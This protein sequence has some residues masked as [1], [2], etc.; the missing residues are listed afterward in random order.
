L[1]LLSLPLPASGP[2]IRIE[3]PNGGEV[4][5][6]GTQVAVRWRTQGIE[7][8]LA[9]LLFKNGEQQAILANGIPDNGLFQ[10]HVATGLAESTG[11]RLRLC[12]LSDLRLNDFSDRDF[13][14]K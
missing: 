6:R 12:S 3:Y 7:G 14:I 11:Y 4:L 13:S 9:L 10:W 1:A 2:S 5:R 8:S